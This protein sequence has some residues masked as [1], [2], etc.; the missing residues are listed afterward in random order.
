LQIF[1]ASFQM[2]TRLT[3][4]LKLSQI[5][6]AAL[7]LASSV[8]SF[9][10]NYYV[11][12]PVPAK[13]TSDGAKNITVALASYSLPSGQV[14]QPYAGF[15]FK[16]L[17][18]VTGD[19]SYN[20]YGVHWS[21]ASGSPPAGLTLNS[22][23]TLTGTP[24][25]GGSASFQVM[26]MYKT[27]A[28]QQA[29]QVFVA[30]V[31]VGLAAGTPP[32][33]IVG[34]AYSYDLKSLLTVT[35]DSGYTPSAVTWTVV[36]SNLPA[37]LHLTAD[38]FIGG[39][40]TASGTGSLTARASY[41]GINGQQTY[42]VVTLALQVALTASTPP[43]ALVGQPY[44]FNVAPLLTVSGD[45]AYSGS[46]VTWSV[47]SG[48]LPA[49]LSLS[50]TGAI[51]GT[52]TAGS[53]GPVVVQA[54]YR[55]VNGQ[56]SYQLVSL[57]IA[58]TL[59]PGTPPQ[60]IVGQAYAY[61]LN[62]LLSVNGDPGYSGSGVTWA[63]VSGSLPDGL[64]LS[65][66]GQITGTPTASG[67]GSLTTRA[68]YRSATGQQTYQ[69]VSLNISVSLNSAT[70]PVANVGTAFSYDFKPLV[71]VSGDSSYSISAVQFRAASLP[72]GLSITA[73][74]VLSGTP[75][76]TAANQNISVVADYRGQDGQQQYTIT[77]NPAFFDF[78]PT[79]S[80]NTV[81]YN[82]YN[83][84]RSAGWNGVAPLRAS[85]T[86]AAGVWVG[87]SS[88]G[89]Y[90]FSTGTG[91]PAQ[92]T[93]K[94]TNN[95]AVVGA[96]GAGG[97][98][99]DNGYCSPSVGGNGGPALYAQYPITVVNNNVIAG[100]GGGGGGAQASWQDSVVAGGSG[101]GGGEGYGTSAGGGA[102]TSQPSYPQ[103]HA[104]GTGSV[105][106]PGAGGAGTQSGKYPSQFSAPW[107]CYSNTAGTGGT[108]GQAG[109]NSGIAS[110]SGCNGA[111]AYYPGGAAGY[112]V[113]GRANVTWTT[114]GTVYGPQQ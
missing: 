27:K 61:N 59:N 14:G 93:L 24:S 99:C 74:G 82:L 32:Q 53:S 91:F 98:G 54:S 52:P 96:G 103:G 67:T 1:D 6:L 101:G 12:V 104:G 25:A 73:A 44:A 100:G 42:Q 87:A 79:I 84:A 34:T 78:N 49:G 71:S 7:L 113:V 41:K 31:T 39:T 63:V 18:S 72:A 108:W 114:S 56:Q 60:A 106:G 11:V 38:G 37:G 48:T 95:G 2:N 58:V 112:A 50:S 57:N 83:A 3:R 47:A 107:Y 65:G 85:V 105:S 19:S 5:A 8:S 77:V 55:G 75:T 86:V 29:F 88:T 26:A 43:Q 4:N 13:T 66:D 16:S 9:A 69:V 23:G 46:G 21:I 80:A 33:A 20:G 64:S 62:P 36:S 97:S 110:G 40:P 35:G 89:N 76:A 10:S 111:G 30:N 94:L 68:T 22:D 28:A 102:T 81:N 109:G 70:L 17:L 51:T 45:P 92:S 15:D 90:A